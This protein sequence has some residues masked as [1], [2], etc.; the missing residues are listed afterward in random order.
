MFRKNLFC[1][2]RTCSAGEQAKADLDS[3][4]EH[5]E[6]LLQKAKSDQVGLGLGQPAQG[7]AG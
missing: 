5:F 1:A 7:A 2:V 6:L 3:Q 4:R